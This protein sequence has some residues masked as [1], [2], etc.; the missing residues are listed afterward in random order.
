VNISSQTK[1]CDFS[2]QKYIFTFYTRCP[3]SY[4]SILATDLNLIII[5]MSETARCSSGWTVMFGSSNCI[6][7][8]LPQRWIYEGA[9]NCHSSD[10]LKKC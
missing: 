7:S 2:F 10:N 9:L 5:D 4:F 1:C 3:L 6:F 8:S